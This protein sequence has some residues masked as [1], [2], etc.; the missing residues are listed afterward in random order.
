MMV[1]ATTSYFDGKVQLL[2]VATAVMYIEATNSC[3]GS[4]DIKQLT[5]AHCCDGKIAAGNGCC[6]GMCYF[7]EGQCGSSSIKA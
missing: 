5:T 7:I 6:G 4:R 3:C 2:I 1:E